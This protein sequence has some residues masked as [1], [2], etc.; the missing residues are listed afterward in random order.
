MRKN[1][2]ITFLNYIKIFKFAYQIQN[3]MKKALLYTAA[4]ALPLLFASC[5]TT[6]R[7]ATMVSVTNEVKTLTIADLDVQDRVTF[8]YK[9]N[10]SERKGGLQ[11]CKEAAVAAMLK[12]YGNAEVLIAP[13]YYYDS[14]LKFIEVSGRPA[15]YKNFRTAP[16]CSPALEVL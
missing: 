11:K 13:E 3:K 1:E 6:V 10:Q 2:S 7:T 12:K 14:D 16:V 8:R 5:K 4:I 9:L 15:S